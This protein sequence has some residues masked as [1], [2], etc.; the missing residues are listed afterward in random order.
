MKKKIIKV[1][2][3][4]VMF[5]GFMT[6]NKISVSADSIDT[7]MPDVNL[8][9]AVAEA[10]TM[11]VEDITKADM[12]NLTS[13]T[14]IEKRISNIQGLEEA[15]NLISLDLSNNTSLPS[16]K[17]T[18][19]DITPLSNLTS[20]TSLKLKHNLVSD[21]SVVANLTSLTSLGLGGNQ[22]V[23]ISPIS[24]LTSLTELGFYTNQVTDISPIKDLTS[25]TILKLNVNNIQSIA[26]IEGMVALTNLELSSNQITDITPIRNL[27]AL[28]YLN[29][30]NNQIND[31]TPLKTHMDNNINIAV[32]N[33]NIILE[34]I[35]IAQINT[36]HTQKNIVKDEHGNIITLTPSTGNGNY[37]PITDAITWS[38]IDIEENAQLQ[39]TWTYASSS[40]RFG[41]S[42]KIIQPY[43]FEKTGGTIEE[44]NETTPTNPVTTSTTQSSVIKTGDNT[45]VEL[46]GLGMLALGTVLLATRRK[47]V[48]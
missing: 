41:Y 33:Q 39:S 35:S 42:G 6:I 45:P 12:K 18:I 19:S 4:L 28:S 48:N 31:I 10:L 36:V 27:T 37:D 15:T 44:S 22:I 14:A 11:N 32:E 30:T 25:L 43:D 40:L 24:G 9:Q 29:L 8:Q 46:L 16:N 17:N 13:L 34:N 2:A 47:K 23:D 38:I 1:V 26:P 5:S 3:L 7:W 20:L 21:I